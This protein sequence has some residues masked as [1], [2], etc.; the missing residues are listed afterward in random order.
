VNI[1]HGT[2][3]MELGTLKLECEV[4]EP[5]LRITIANHLRGRECPKQSPFVKAWE[6]REFK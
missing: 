5:V 4:E 1:E 6:D 2:A 3:N